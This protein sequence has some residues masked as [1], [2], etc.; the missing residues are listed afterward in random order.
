MTTFGRV[1]AGKGVQQRFP[2]LME[3]EIFH[4]DIEFISPIM[5][6]TAKEFGQIFLGR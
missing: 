6:Q 3:K 4:A 1:S 2:E 5:E